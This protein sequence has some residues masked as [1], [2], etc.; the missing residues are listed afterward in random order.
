[1]EPLPETQ[2]VLADLAGYV[3]TDVAATLL[4]MGTRAKE[5]VPECVGLSL[6]RVEDGITLTLVASSD[7]SAV[8]DAVQYLDGGP[9]VDAADKAEPLDVRHT[10]LLDESRWQMYARATAAA[11]VASSLSLPIIR[12][13]RVVGG[14]NLYASTPNAFDGR[15]EELARALHASAEG[16]VTNADLTFETRRRAAE[17]PARLADLED[18]DI[19]TGIVA[20]SQDVGIDTA[21][22][23]LE[24]RT[25]SR[26]HAGSSRPSGPGAPRRMSPPLHLVPHV[27]AAG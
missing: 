25:Q 13:G 17:A 4:T 6:G 16:A 12:E 9:C 15:H 26:D 2:Q 24:R 1:M 5:I 23:R 27:G 22:A 11:G 8:L 19:A 18:I 10:E 7:E 21:L 20:A 14:V 3:G